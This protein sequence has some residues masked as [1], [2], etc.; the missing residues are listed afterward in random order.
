MRLRAASLFSWGERGGRNQ[1]IKRQTLDFSS[2]ELPCYP[3]RRDRQ[4]YV[5]L[6]DKLFFK[7]FGILQFCYKEIHEISSLVD[8]H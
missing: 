5:A 6:F 3:F 2:K 4:K 1:N 7:Q 8:Q